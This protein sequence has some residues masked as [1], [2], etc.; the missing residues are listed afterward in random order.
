VP[1]FGDALQGVGKVVR[2][3]GSAA[4]TGRTIGAVA[5]VGKASDIS[6]DVFREIVS[7]PSPSY[8]LSPEILARVP[9]GREVTAEVFHRQGFDALPQAL[10]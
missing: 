4:D 10:S 3:A 2:G 7:N 1:F 8:T 9:K 5:E 6:F